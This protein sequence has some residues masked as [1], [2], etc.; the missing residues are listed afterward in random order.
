[1]HPATAPDFRQLA[2][3]QAR[4]LDAGAA[5]TVL[6][7]AALVFWLVPPPARVEAPTC[8]GSR[9]DPRSACGAAVSPIEG[10]SE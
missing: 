3:R 10:R 6:A 9:F 4:W 8:A 1:M 7:L 5:A 2:H